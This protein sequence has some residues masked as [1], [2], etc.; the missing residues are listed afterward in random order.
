VPPTSAE[1]PP[2]AAAS[3]PER[4]RTLFYSHDGFGLGHFQRNFNLATALVRSAP[5]ATALLLGSS[6]HGFDCRLP[7][8]VDW[9][10]LPSVTKTELAA[11]EPRT[12]HIGRPR[13][14]A[15][16]RAVI[17]AAFSE[18]RP[19]MVVVDHLPTGVWGELLPAL[20]ACARWPHPPR[21]VLGLRDVL[22][23]PTVTERRW[24]RDGSYPALEQLY[25][26]VL[27][28]GDP[29]IVP[30]ADLYGLERRLGKRITYCGYVGPTIRAGGAKRLR[31]QLGVRPHER[32]V[33]A[34]AGGGRDGF[35][36]LQACAHA[37]VKL[38]SR[39]P[40]RGVLLAGPLMPQTKLGNLRRIVAGTDVAVWWQTEDP[41]S[42]LAAADLVVG[43]AGYNTMVESLMLG[44]RLL[45]LPRT[46]PS[47]E[48]SLRAEAFSRHGLLARIEPHQLSEGRLAS[49]IEHH[50][51]VEFPA[52]PRLRLNGRQVA[53]RAL[54]AE[55]DATRARPLSNALLQATRPSS[56]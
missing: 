3:E 24:L 8:G 10:K 28:Y 13:L 14:D 5:G 33:V 50:L 9:L 2:G 35:P 15:L 22:D 20:K 49:L 40:I 48:Q 31:L 42:L 56:A 39:A 54:L 36:L 1:H 4:P 23:R 47:A 19:H 51:E 53:V 16:R 29:R 41:P 43:M 34:T 38:G 18:F 27:I 52:R 30:T 44:R 46:G 37:L 17:E 7:S 25:H 21:V 11:W 26:R 45:V 55:L 32:L 12:L 6:P